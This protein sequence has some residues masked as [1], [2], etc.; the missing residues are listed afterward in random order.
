MMGAGYD[1]G[2]VSK[3][4]VEC[5]GEFVMITCNF[6]KIFTQMGGSACRGGQRIVSSRGAARPGDQFDC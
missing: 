2:F 1:D 5:I 4:K 6:V 3:P